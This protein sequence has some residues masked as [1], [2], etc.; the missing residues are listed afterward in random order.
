VGGGKPVT[1]GRPSHEAGGGGGRRK[2]GRGGAG[3]KPG[4]LGG[5]PCRLLGMSI[6]SKGDSDGVC[7]RC[8]DEWCMLSKLKKEA[9]KGGWVGKMRVRERSKFR[10]RLVGTKRREHGQ[11]RVVKWGVLGFVGGEEKI[12][13]EGGSVWERTIEKR[14][15]RLDKLADRGGDIRRSEG[16]RVHYSLFNLS[17]RN[18]R[19]GRVWMTQGKIAKRGSPNF[20]LNSTP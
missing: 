14:N 6:S 16:S 2:K 17:K 12:N 11:E 8:I 9:R 3:I 5:D 13:V 18:I 19:H 4:T 10:W 1:D 15:N 20:I 7:Q